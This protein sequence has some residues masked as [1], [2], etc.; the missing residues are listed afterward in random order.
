MNW[1]N[2][3]VVDEVFDMMKWW[4]DKGIDGF[5]MDVINLIG[6]P[7][8]MPDSVRFGERY[9]GYV[10]DPALYAN[11]AVTHT[12]LKEMRKKVLSKYDVMTVG[13]TPMVTPDIV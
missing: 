5:R 9:D 13:E 11:N 4:L 12:Y 7:E 2:P 3:K 10:F 8:G 1:E 6:K